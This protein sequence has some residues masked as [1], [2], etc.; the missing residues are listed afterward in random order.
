[1]DARVRGLRYW[2]LLA[3]AVFAIAAPHVL[4]PDRDLPLLQ[5]LN[6]SPSGLLW[7]QL[8]K[9]QPIVILFIIPCLP[10]AFWD[11]EHL[12]ENLGMKALHAMSTVLII[13]GTA[14]YSFGRYVN[15]GP[16][17]QAWQE[18]QKGDW[19]RTMKENTS[20][21]FS[22]P[23]GMV[24][25]LLA[26][27]HVF[28]IGLLILVA[29]A[30]LGQS[31]ALL[32]A[33]IPGAVLLVWSVVQ[34]LRQLPH[35]DHAYYATNAFYSEIFRRAGGMRVGTREMIPYSAVYWSPARYKPHVWASLRQLD[36][37]LPLGRMM[38]M[39]HGLLWVLFYLDTSM[40]TVSVYLLLLIVAKNGV[41]YVLTRP[42]F[43]PQPFQL[44]RQSERD[45]IFTRF[46]VNL[47]WTLPLLLSLLVVATLDASLLFK[48]ALG[49]TALDVA[50]AFA[51]AL[52]FTYTTEHRYRQHFS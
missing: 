7:H 20:G 16:M 37:K 29:A 42:A 36:R 44:G 23:E 12:T 35:Y 38:A 10:L 25:A 1:M 31:V 9:W 8:K 52:L 41:S 39:A 45:W 18:G 34:L 24:P 43:A 50:V 48:H 30:Y 28:L 32:L 5:R 2:T 14:L 27:Q 26:T 21:L 6:C 17:S 22:V 13:L 11:P 15:I 47:R 3:T 19:Y 46:L 4:L 51:T 49:W 40:R 33:V